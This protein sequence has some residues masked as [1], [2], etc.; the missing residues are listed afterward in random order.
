[1]ETFKKD[2]MLNKPACVSWKGFLL[3][4]VTAASLIYFTR[5]WFLFLPVNIFTKYSW[6][7]QALHRLFPH[8]RPSSVIIFPVYTIFFIIFA[9]IVWISVAIF[10]R[11]AKVVS[12]KSCQVMTGFVVLSLTL[13]WL[14]WPTACNT[15]ESFTDI[16]NQ[17]CTCA[18]L[19]FTFYPPWVLADGTSTDY[20]IGWDQPVR[21]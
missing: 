2:K 3:L 7:F 12:T 15:H 8:A 5:L 17:T 14:L 16:P 6:I 4:G 9:L 18:G 21:P 19:T 13:G 10:Y 20:C 11:L 1:M